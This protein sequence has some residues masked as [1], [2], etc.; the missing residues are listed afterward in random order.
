M[1]TERIGRYEIKMEQGRGGMATVYQAYDPRFGRDVAIKVLPPQFTHDPMFRERFDREAHTIA[2]LEHAAIVPVYDFGEDNGQPYLVMRYMTGGSLASRLKDGPVPIYQAAAVIQRVSAALDEAHKRG[3]I[4]RDIKPGNVLFDQYDDAFLSDFGIARLTEATAALT[5]SAIIG[6]PAYMS[7]EQA[8]GDASVDGRADVYSLGVI[9]FEMLSGQA[10]YDADTPMGIAI[11]HILDPI[12][13]IRS[14][15]PDL[16]PALEGLITRTMAKDPNHRY[17]TASEMAAALAAVAAGEAIPAFAGEAQEPATIP[18]EQP[19][20]VIPERPGWNGTQ[21]SNPTP[22]FIEAELPANEKPAVA[23]RLDEAARA[24]QPF[25]SPVSS[26]LVDVRLIRAEERRATAEERRAAAE[27]RKAQAL[28]T[29]GG[30]KK[31]PGFFFFGCLAVVVLVAIFGIGGVLGAIR[32]FSGAI[33]G[34]NSDAP[35]FQTVEFNAPL[36]KIESLEVVLELGA[37]SADVYALD[38]DSEFAAEGEYDSTIV[39]PVVYDAR[40][41]SGVGVLTIEE[42]PEHGVPGGSVDIGL[43]RTVPIDLTV[44]VGA[45]ENTLDL[46]GLNVTSLVVETDAG[47]VDLILPSYGILDVVIEAGLGALTIEPPEDAAELFLTSLDIRAAG[48]SIH[49][50][51]P[52]HGSF[53]VDIEAGIAEVEVEVPDALAA[54]LEAEGGLG[55]VEVEHD[56][57]IQDSDDQAVWETEDYADAADKVEIVVDASLGHVSIKD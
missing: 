7:P 13:Q 34:V 49:L 32:G 38:E 12:P 14:I 8:R 41:P 24:Q 22:P 30:S 10:P 37:T 28:E 33:Q 1:S 16:P 25:A 20:I 15:N 6:T 42:P 45:G 27:E 56:T 19:Q 31:G 55:N 48:G 17:Q 26:P 21:V 39:L 50:T 2:A 46:T 18:L 57:L 5:G 40:D 23:A 54:H 53:K 51:L 35:D 29:H 3:I 11:K 9:L 47:S 44:K 36:D 4:H 43:T 52:D